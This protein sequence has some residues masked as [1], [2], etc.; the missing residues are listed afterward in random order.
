MF[1]HF[2]LSLSSFF[3]LMGFNRVLQ[4]TLSSLEL[5]VYI[6]SGPSASVSD[7][8]ESSSCELQERIG[9]SIRDEIPRPSQNPGRQKHKSHDPARDLTIHVL[10]KFS[11]VTKFARDTS[12]QLF[13]E[14]NSN[15]YGA[16]ERKSSSY[17][18]PDVPHKPSMDAEIA[19]E[20]GPVPSDPLEV[21]IFYFKS[22]S[23]LGPSGV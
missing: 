12:S 23:I 16:V 19:L 14:S 10:E 22:I 21:T 7:G 3:L 17:T 5:P 11:L 9:D 4:K 8:G 2:T 1:L 6:A 18:L 20:E 13:R 15:G